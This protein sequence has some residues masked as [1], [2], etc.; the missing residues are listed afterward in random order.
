MVKGPRWQ[1]D[2]TDRSGSVSFR[3]KSMTSALVL[4]LGR[5]GMAAAELLLDEGVRV[6]ALDGARSEAVACRARVLRLKDAR[7]LTGK[8]ALAAAWSGRVRNASGRADRLPFDL[9]VVSPGIAAEHPWLRA[10]EQAGIPLVSELELGAQRC[11]WPIIA[12]TGSNGKSTAVK[13]CAEALT[14]AGQRVMIAGNYGTPLCEAVRA[15]SDLDRIVVEVSSFQLEHVNRFKPKIGI[16]L[17]IQPNHLDR[18]GT[19][20]NYVQIKTRL[21]ARMGQGDTAIV[22]EPQRADIRRR[23]CQGNAKAAD[24]RWI[25]FGTGRGA[26]CRIGRNGAVRLGGSR[27]ALKGTAFGNPVMAETAAAVAAVLEAC[28]VDIRHTETAARAFEPLPHRFQTVG[29]LGG[30]RFVN[31]SKATTLSAMQ[32]AL[33]RADGPV[34]LIVGGRL[35]EK[36]MNF[37][38]ETLVMRAKKIYGIGEDG[39]VLMQAWR[40]VVACRYCGDLKRAVAAAWR[41]AKSGESVL[42]SPGCA[43][44][45]QFKDFAERGRA[46][47]AAV[48]AIKDSQ[49]IKEKDV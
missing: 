3:K 26:V 9:C 38:K 48:E 36:N 12:V 35:K 40:D 11:R 14:L 39:Q 17:N 37:V 29:I 5:S 45:D 19:M 31:D 32:A 47:V 49:T 20:E 24:M 21:F 41:E 33:R 46:F 4:G 7:V 23:V 6:T 8:R 34:R 1:D 43:S 15:C 10:V 18:H 13:L 28:G 44:F 27:V 30:V 42:F 2:E 22:P 25:G 16:L